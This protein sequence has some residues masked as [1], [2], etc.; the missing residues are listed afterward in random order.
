L[1]YLRGDG[2]SAA[3]KK[4]LVSLVVII[5]GY[6]LL[7]DKNRYLCASKAFLSILA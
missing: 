1:L 3:A 4:A 2:D 6:Y 7:V 5:L